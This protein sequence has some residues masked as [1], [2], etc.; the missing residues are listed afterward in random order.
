MESKNAMKKIVISRLKDFGVAEQASKNKANIFKI[1]GR[2]ISNQLI[3][4]L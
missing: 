1:Y 4:I 3:K 2:K